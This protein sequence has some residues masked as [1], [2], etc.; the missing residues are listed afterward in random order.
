MSATNAVVLDRRAVSLDHM[1]R[2]SLLVEHV[3]VLR[4]DRLKP[5]DLLQPGKQCVN[6]AGRITVKPVDHLAAGLV[7]DG[8]ITTEPVDVEDPLSA[9]LSIE[10]LR[11]P[12]V[13]DAGQRGNPGPGQGHHM[14]GLL[15]H[16]L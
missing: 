11:S 15:Y 5:T 12:K 6:R 7:V 2:A 3:D 9:G 1:A 14:V 8:R 10:P 4:N 13:G 16:R